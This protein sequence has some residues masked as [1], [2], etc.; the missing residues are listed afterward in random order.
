MKKRLK[1]VWQELLA[2]GS[3]GVSS[4]VLAPSD[5]TSMF[6]PLQPLQAYMRHMWESLLPPFQRLSTWHSAFCFF[7]QPCWILISPQPLQPHPTFTTLLRV[8]ATSQALGISVSAIFPGHWLRFP[9]VEGFLLPLPTWEE[10]PSSHILWPFYIVPLK[11]KLWL[12]N[13]VFDIWRKLFGGGEKNSSLSLS[14]SPPIPGFFKNYYLTM[15]FLL[16]NNFLS[17]NWIA[18]LF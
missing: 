5:P 8:Q 10:L 15:E 6:Y 1:P 16:L 12:L 14:R 3:V 9:A 13:F 7:L 2:W 11:M 4:Q 17:Q 18:S